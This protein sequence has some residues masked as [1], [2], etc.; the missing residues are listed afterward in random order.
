MANPSL[1]VLAEA[2][3]LSISTAS[4]ALSG[5]PSVRPEVRARIVALAQKHGYRRNDL[6]GKLMSH[7]RAGGTHRFLGNLGIIHVPS[8]SQPRVLPAQRR[9]M[10]GAAERATELGFKLYEFSAER[11]GLDAR[12]YARVLRARG[13][14]GVIM[15]YSEA[16][17]TLADFPWDDFAAIEIDYGRREPLLHTVCLDQ[18]MTLRRALERLQGMGFRRMGLFLSQFKDA[19]IAHKWSG[20]FVSFQRERGKAVGGVP[21]FSPE[22]IEEKTFLRWYR[23]HRPDLVIGHVDDAV[24]WLTRAGLR[25]PEDVSFFN[26]SWT[27]RKRPCAGLDLRLELQGR[28]AAETVISQLQHNDRGLPED[29]RSIMVIGRW[30]NG[31][32]L[33]A[34]ATRKAI[35]TTTS[36]PR[37]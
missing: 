35:S 11:D 12:G 14:H 4:R 33:A 24:T 2:S 21:I 34:R 37:A 9:I 6:V 8:P 27:E 32:T 15:L 18:F 36:G 1:R 16:I 5:H 7:V 19:R 23:R 17:D 10:A 13:V 26:L 3:G 31:P 28:V 25:V 30:V 29:P 22:R 20:A